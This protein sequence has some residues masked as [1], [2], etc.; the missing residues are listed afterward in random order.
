MKFIFLTLLVLFATLILL[1]FG[2]K[3]I[4]YEA[5]MRS[6]KESINTLPNAEVM[7]IW[8]HKD[9][10]LEEIAARIKV[11]NSG[12]IVLGGLSEDSFRYPE[13]VGIQS[14]GE[15]SF[16]TFSC[17]ERLGIGNWLNIGTESKMGKELGLEFT[18]VKD[19]I[20]HY[21]QI[22]SFVQ[23]LKQ[24]PEYNYFENSNSELFFFVNPVNSKDRDP[25]H[26]LHGFDRIFEYAKTLPWKNADCVQ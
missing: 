26:E 16:R 20:D 22:L 23:N 1:F 17:G 15:Y 21:D 2:Y 6:I 9:V 24:V 25:I 14:I 4:F 5:E 7:N 8:G 12:E 13:L 3:K 18:S 10:T 11:N 19:V